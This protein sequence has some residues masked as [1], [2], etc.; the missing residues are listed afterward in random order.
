MKI[1]VFF[2][3]LATV[4]RCFAQTDTNVIG[5]G[6]WSEVVVDSKG[7]GLRGRLLVYDD[8]VRESENHAR[9]YLELQH[10]FRDFWGFPMEFHFDLSHTNELHFELHD[11]H[12]QPM[13]STGIAIVGMLPPPYRVVLPCDSTLRFRAD[14]CNLGP[15]SRPDGLEILTFPVC[16]MLPPGSTNSYFLSATFTPPKDSPSSPDNHV[17]QGTLRLPAVKIQVGKP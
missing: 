9:V 1:I 7:Y 4:P 16:W 2:L 15:G 14:S 5:T 10:V 3:W 8:H 13:A 11:A 17:W 12:G 6:T